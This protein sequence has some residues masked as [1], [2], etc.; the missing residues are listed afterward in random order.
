MSD[1]LIWTLL[2]HLVCIAQWAAFIL[3]DYAYLGRGRRFRHPC[4]WAALLALAV[5]ALS[6]LCG[7]GFFNIK[8]VVSN[9]IYLLVI[10]LLFGGTAVDRMSACIINGILCLLTENTVSFVFARLH[11]I[12]PGEVWHYR[13]CLAALVISILLVGIL[14]ARFLCRWNHCSA[15]DPLQALLMSFFPGVVVLLNIFIMISSNRR[16]PTLLD[17]MLTVGLTIAVLVHLAIVQMFNDQ[18]VQRQNSRYRAQLEQQRAEALL[19]SYT[20]QRRL[21]HEFTNHMTALTALLDQGDLKGAQAY[22][23]SVS[24]LVAA[25][26]TIMDTHNPLLDSI[27]SKK[28]EEAAKVG[29]NIYFDLCDLKRMPFDSM[30]MVIVLSNLLDNAT[31]AAAQAL[32]PE[33]HVRIRKTPEEYLIS[34]RNRVQEDLLLEEGKLPGTTKKESGHGMG[35]ANVQDVLRK[36]GAEYTV[37]CRDRWFRFTCAIPCAVH[38]MSTDN[39]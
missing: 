5:L 2:G 8:S 7:F 30:D 32:P 24:K 27:L 39:L 18:V 12:C 36:Y 1:S 6:V 17:L 9:I 23:A 34:V 26:T 4:V 29:V 10:A 13:T 22:I 33:V 38:D 11:G 28:Y 16:V 14:A 19:D 3:V 37:S 31:R 15:L 20:E 21:T 35:L 25:G